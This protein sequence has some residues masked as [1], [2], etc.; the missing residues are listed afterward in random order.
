MADMGELLGLLYIIR[1]GIR[2]GG[3]KVYVHCWGG[4]GNFFLFS[5]QLIM[6]EYIADNFFDNFTVPN[7]V[8]SNHNDVT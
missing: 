3:D 7:E 4:R 1:N 8:S 5:V 2:R 6:Y